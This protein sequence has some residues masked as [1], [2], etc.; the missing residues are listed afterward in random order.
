M[1]MKR[2]TKGHYY[3][4]AKSDQ[5]PEC[6]RIAD[7]VGIT[8]PVAR[9]PD[10]QPE[11][12]DHTIIVMQKELGADPVVGWLVCVEG[13]EKGQDHRIHAENNYI[14]RSEKMD[15][16]IRGDNTV[17]RENHAVVSYDPQSGTFY[18]AP[19]GGRGIVRVNG[20]AVLGTVELTP[21]DKL[22]IG[23]TSLLFVP[24]C[25]EEFRWT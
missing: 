20:K 6:R 17:S 8:V 24:F 2:C 12:P 21:F 19:S 9:P 5:C 13:A 10:G 16:C 22:E 4:Q 3:D 14:G 7:D 1:E 23:G 15:I 25:G 11:D 18:F